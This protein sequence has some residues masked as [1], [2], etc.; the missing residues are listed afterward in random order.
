MWPWKKKERWKV[1]PGDSLGTLGEKLGCQYLEK[2]GYKIV[3][4]NYKNP[5][6]RRLGE[7]DI[8]ATI[9]K[10][11]VFVEVKTREKSGLAF[12]LP[13]ENINRKKLHKLQKIAAYYLR[14]NKWLDREY[15]FDA[16]SIVYD[17]VARSAKIRH[18]E[19]IFF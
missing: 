11:I 14:Q 13:E 3:E 10:K 5:K 2:K 8:I 17:G 16:L 19:S 12:G 1:L 7:I 18:L 4:V 6:G 15:A 9:G